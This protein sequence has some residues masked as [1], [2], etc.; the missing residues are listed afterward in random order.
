MVDWGLGG[1]DG[2]PDGIMKSRDI[3]PEL[4]DDPDLDPQVHAHAL[5][6]LGRINRL[7]RVAEAMYGHLRRLSAISPKPLRVLDIATGGG[8]L[9]IYWGK[10]ARE[11]GYRL[12]L[13][14]T[15]LSPQA[16][17]I[18]ARSAEAAKLDIDWFSANVL[19][20]TLPNDFDI[21]TCSLFLHHLADDEIVQV[22]RTMR[23]ATD[24]GGELRRL[25][26][27]DLER[28]RLNLC[29]VSFASHLVSRSKIVHVDAAL[30]V[31]AA[32]KRREFAELVETALDL[33]PEIKP[34]FPCRFLSEIVLN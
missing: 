18:A 4:M 14:G 19:E 26:I 2:L 21:V 30:S 29:L 10:R 22:L 3:K 15:D 27:C 6:G 20:D 12:D 13:S 24:R 34:L 31:R 16:I 23:D 32:L 11:E 8:D 33:K 9:P 17:A 1:I 28:S 7:T 5:A 25:I